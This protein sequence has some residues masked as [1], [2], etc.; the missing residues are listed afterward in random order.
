MSPVLGPQLGE[1]A[2]VATRDDSPNNQGS[3][4][5]A[6]WY[7]YVDK[8]L[9][10]ALGWDVDGPFRTAFCGGDPNVSS[11]P[12]W[13]HKHGHGDDHGRGHKHGHGGHG[14]S[15]RD[16]AAC[17]ASLWAAI[18]AAGNEL[19]TEQGTA[20]PA[21]WRKSAIPERI[22]FQPGLL[23]DTMRWTNRPTFQQAISYSGHR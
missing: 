17:R 15:N 22:V 19:T 23:P 3:S 2:S 11:S 10:S 4:F 7:G 12:Q 1:L 20:D 14:Q 6:G 21:A 9:R 8:D 16:F 5:N 18:D 13:S